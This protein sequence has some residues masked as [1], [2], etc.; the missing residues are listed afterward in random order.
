MKQK[1]VVIGRGYSG[2]LSIIR[3][4][5]E[6][7]CNITVI[8]LLPSLKIAEKVKKCD[9]TLDAYSK[10]VSRVFYSESYNKEMLLDILMNHCADKTQ[11]TFIFPDNDFSAAA[12]DLYR[13]QLKEHFYIP[14]INDNAGAVK[15]WMDKVKQKN[16]ARSVGLNVANATLVKAHDCQFFIPDTVKY[17]C[18]AKPLLSVAGGKSALRRCNTKEDLHKHIKYVASMRTD[19]KI[20]VEDFKAIDKEYAV[21]GFSDGKEVVIP[22]MLQLLNVAHGSHFGVAMRGRVF[23]CAGYEELIGKFKTFVKETGFY[24]IFDIDFFESAGVMYF[25]ELNLRFGGSG[26]AITRM[27]VNLPVMMIRSFL[28][29][30]ISGMKKAVTGEAT[31]FNERMALDDWYAGFITM[32]EY[33]RMQRDSDI[34]FVANDDDKL[35]YEKLAKELFAKR[36]KK[37]IKHL[38]GR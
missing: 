34:K 8:S 36:C 12:V 25:C 15:E 31:Y 28:G 7:D 9:F 16:L 3:S 6:L 23:P 2:R 38:L 18:F 5:A 10:Y 35:P 17:P 24:G 21:L 13:D 26:Y 30:D 33:K 22:G 1:I 11:K 4:L 19:V 20:L 14:H 32:E 27:G 37:T 29:E